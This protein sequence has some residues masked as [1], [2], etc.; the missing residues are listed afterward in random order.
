MNRRAWGWTYLGVVVF[1]LLVGAIPLLIYARGPKT[2]GNEGY[3]AARVT[4]ASFSLGIAALAAGIAVVQYRINS[5]NSRVE[6]S[7][8]FWRRSNSDEFTEHH[9]VLVDYWIEHDRTS[10]AKLAE[11]D[12]KDDRTIKRATEYLLDFYDEACAAVYMGACDEDA[13]YFYLGDLMTYHYGALE[14]FIDT[15]RRVKGRKL[16]WDCY[17]Y[18]ILKWKDKTPPSAEKFQKD[19][20]NRIKKHASFTL[21]HLVFGLILLLCGL[22]KTA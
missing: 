2:T 5:H 4:V 15:W 6:R 20:D 19:L 13:M 22:R 17:T 12:D 21:S 1:A 16:K 18:M 10:L 3:L 11:T 7:M 8:S 14:G 9:R